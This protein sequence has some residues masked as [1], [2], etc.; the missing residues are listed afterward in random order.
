MKLCDHTIPQVIYRVRRIRN[1]DAQ[2][3]ELHLWIGSSILPQEII[4]FLVARNGKPG[5]AP[6]GPEYAQRIESLMENSQSILALDDSHKIWYHPIQFEMDDNLIQIREN[7][8]VQMGVPPTYQYLTCMTYDGEPII[9][10]HNYFAKKQKKREEDVAID[11]PRDPFEEMGMIEQSASYTYF[12]TPETAR[13]TS[14]LILS[15]FPML[16]DEIRLISLLD[17]LKVTQWST[18]LTGAQSQYLTKYWPNYTEYPLAD[19]FLRPKADLRTGYPEYALL[20]QR[21]LETE[22]IRALLNQVDW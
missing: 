19:E 17:F 22:K 12:Q 1:Q 5:T 11:F 2:Q 6:V 21:V 14:G 4:E 16:N 15:E 8:F 7:I 18:K 20:N 10:G 9:M 13:D 3:D